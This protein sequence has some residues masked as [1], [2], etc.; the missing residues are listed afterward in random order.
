MFYDWIFK[1]PKYIFVLTINL[2]VFMYFS[3]SHYS[4]HFNIYT[5][6]MQQGLPIRKFV[7]LETHV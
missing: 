7:R 4:E 6:T 3:G 5:R 2:T 1:W